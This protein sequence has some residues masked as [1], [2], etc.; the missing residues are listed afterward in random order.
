MIFLLWC[1]IINELLLL[2][3]EVC[4]LA[5]EI[6]WI[7]PIP[8]YCFHICSFLCHYNL[9]FYCISLISIH[10]SYSL[11]STSLS[12]YCLFFPFPYSKTLQKCCLYSTTG[13][14]PTLNPFHLGFRL[15]QASK[16][17]LFKITNG[18]NSWFSPC[19]A[20]QQ[21][22]TAD[23]CLLLKLFF[24]DWFPG[25][26]HLLLALL[27]HYQSSIPLAGSSSPPQT[28]K[29]Q[30]SV[31][32]LTFFILYIHCFG[33]YFQLHN[34]EYFPFTDESKYSFLA[35]FLSLNSRFVSATTY[36]TLPLG[37]ITGISN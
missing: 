34:F 36:L 23:Y 12:C 22:L 9:S 3:T 35:W 25:Y 32:L 7:L 1:F 2:L 14:S 28:F 37:F 17:C 13:F 18:L 10:I 26:H 16:N 11:Y 6:S 21:N 8:G 24:S 20:Y 33:N 29:L 27:S 4:Q 15:H 5:H 31:F 30:W 19:L